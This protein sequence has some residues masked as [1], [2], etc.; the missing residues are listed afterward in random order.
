[1]SGTFLPFWHYN[2]SIN[3][4]DNDYGMEE[5]EE[6]EEEVIDEGI[7]ED[8]P[9]IQHAFPPLP[10]AG[11][12]NTK[13]IVTLEGV[14]SE[15]FP[16]KEEPLGIRSRL[17]VRPPPT[18][19]EDQVEEYIEEVEEWEEEEEMPEEGMPSVV[20]V[21]G[22]VTGVKARLQKAATTQALNLQPG[23]CLWACVFLPVN[24]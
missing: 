19:M 1:M 22:L 9:P 14:D 4:S 23:K 2:Q 13:F 20:P 12:E 10:V 11:G 15:G 24:I 18:D 5:V 8:Q 17:G 21:G 7:E 3:P 16:E 6:V